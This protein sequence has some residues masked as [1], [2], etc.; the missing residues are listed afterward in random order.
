MRASTSISSSPPRSRSPCRRSTRELAREVHAAY[1]RY[2]AE[3]C[4]AD[5]ARLKATVPVLADADERRAPRSFARSPTSRGWRRS[6][7]CFPEGLPIDDPVLDPLW[8][9]MNEADLP[10]MHHSFFYEPPYFPGLSR[11]VGQRR[12]RPRRR[13]SVGRATTARLPVAE[14]RVRPVPQPADRVLRVQ[15]RLVAGLADAAARPGRVHARCVARV[16][17]RSRSTTP[18]RAASS[19]ASSSTRARRSPSRSTSCSATA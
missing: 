9:A 17:A 3:Y 8:A 4:S 18:G 19:A 16:G 10:I 13:P 6:R 15:R 7:R 5:P 11:H 1:I 2:I 14:R 12:R